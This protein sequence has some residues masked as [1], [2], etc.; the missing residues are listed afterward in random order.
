MD[1]GIVLT[2]EP[3]GYKD[4]LWL[5]IAPSANGFST[6]SEEEDDEYREILGI[7]ADADLP[8][9]RVRRFGNTEMEEFVSDKLRRYRKVSGQVP[10]DA[11]EKVQ[12]EGVA[13]FVL[14]D[15]DGILDDDRKK[16]TYNAD[17]GEKM[18]RANR[19]FY[20]AV[21][22]ASQEEALFRE[23]QIQE[24]GEDLGNDS[25]GS[26][27][28]AEKSKGSKKQGSSSKKQTSG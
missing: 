1:H 2:A 6:W 18:F 22:Q 24:E 27:S 16:L 7:D 5:Y 23:E 17:V 11:T 20:L 4:D 15:W 9:I 25:S 21:I 19:K 10:D 14:L 8:R 28:G 3:T 13:R 12:R 26:S